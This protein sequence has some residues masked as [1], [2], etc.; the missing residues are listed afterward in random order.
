MM[1]DSPKLRR[2]SLFF[3]KVKA[4]LRSPEV[5]V[6]KAVYTKGE[7]LSRLSECCWNFTLLTVQ[8]A[9]D[10]LDISVIFM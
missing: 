7:Y 9:L 6:W 10:E 1:C 5:E 4:S 2:R 3:I 8:V